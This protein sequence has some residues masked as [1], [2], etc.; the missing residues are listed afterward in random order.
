MVYSR[1]GDDGTVS[2]GRVRKDSAVIVACGDV[3]ELNSIMSSVR[4]SSWVTDRN[5]GKRK[6]AKNIQL[7]LFQLGSY[8]TSNGKEGTI[9]ED[10]IFRLERAI[11]SS[12]NELPPLRGFCIPGNTPEAALIH[13]AR[14]I[15]RRAERSVVSCG[16]EG[17]P[18]QWLNRLSDLLFSWGRLC[19]Y[20]ARCEEQRHQLMTQTQV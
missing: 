9:T 1:T 6:E 11:D 7:I 17:V 19:D 15:A 18:V 4:L 13:H 12:E 10:D 20:D 5:D 8:I 16:I 3:D 14:A 2:F